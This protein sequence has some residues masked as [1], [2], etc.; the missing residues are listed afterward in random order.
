MMPKLRLRVSHVHLRRIGHSCFHH[1]K[2]LR[3]LN[4]RPRVPPLSFLNPY[5]RTGKALKPILLWLQEKK[6]GRNRCRHSLPKPLHRC[7]LV[8]C[9]PSLW[10]SLLPAFETHSAEP[11]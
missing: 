11:R 1:R 9:W 10:R 6:F 8:C 4:A 3:P 7:L 5:A 2:A